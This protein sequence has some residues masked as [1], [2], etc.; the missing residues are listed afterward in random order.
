MAWW[1]LARP[2]DTS[3]MVLSRLSL[4]S[5]FL[6]GV[7]SISGDPALT[8]TSSDFCSSLPR[9]LICIP[10]PPI[11]LTGFSF[12]SH[13]LFVFVFSPVLPDFSHFRFRLPL[14][15]C[16]ILKTKIV[17]I[18]SRSELQETKLRT[19]DSIQNS[20]YVFKK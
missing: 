14:K 20:V 5:F 19:K 17:S 12:P 11:L 3:V 4:P 8:T 15:D 1:N 16:I 18:C 7:A 6:G 13:L 9:P 2:S 10:H